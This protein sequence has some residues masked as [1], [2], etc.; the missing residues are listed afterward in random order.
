MCNSNQMSSVPLCRSR[1]DS[2][3]TLFIYNL[4]FPHFLIKSKFRNRKITYIWWQ[5]QVGFER[6]YRHF[7]VSLRW[8]QSGQALAQG[9]ASNARFQPLI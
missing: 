2:V 5:N 9:S 3:Y 4:L 6:A 1:R 8:K 7:K